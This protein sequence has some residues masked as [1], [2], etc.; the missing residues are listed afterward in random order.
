MKVIFKNIVW[1]LAVY[2][3]LSAGIFLMIKM[4]IAYTGFRDDAGF[5]RFKQDLTGNSLWMTAF[6]IHVF[7]AVFCLAAGFTQFSATLLKK[8]RNLHR[9]LGR[10]YVY[11]IL[12]IN[13][14]VAMIMAIYANGGL[15]TQIA[16]VLLD[17]LWFWFTLKA[18]TD[19]RKG[20]VKGHKEFMIRSYALTLSALSLRTWKM[21]LVNTTSLDVDT[22]YMIDAWLAFIPNLVVAEVIIHSNRNNGVLSFAAI[23]Q[24]VRFHLSASLRNMP[25]LKKKQQTR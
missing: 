20:N 25:V 16:F 17:C 24:T 5:L 15:P 19:V 2:L 13:F 1:Y 8:N 18:V 11:N 6:Y 12:L 7:S 4:I 9:I 21:I 23:F 10:C 14:P 22:I 3:V